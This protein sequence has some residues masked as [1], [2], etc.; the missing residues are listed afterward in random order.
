MFHLLFQAFSST[1]FIIRLDVKAPG[2][3]GL[4]C[5]TWKHFKKQKLGDDSSYT[6]LSKSA[7][8]DREWRWQ[9]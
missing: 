4:G 8:G 2:P 5:T 3:H 7:N 9:D 6:R 1:I